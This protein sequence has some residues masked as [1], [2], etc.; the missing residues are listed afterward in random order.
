MTA[1]VMV[2]LGTLAQPVT[3]NA[4]VPVATVPVAAATSCYGGAVGWKTG[5]FG[6]SSTE[7]FGPYYTTSRCT[8]INMRMTSAPDAMVASACVRFG[9]PTAA[10]NRYTDFT[11]A[12]NSWKTIATTVLDG[13]KFYVTVF[14]GNG[15]YPVLGQFA[16]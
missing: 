9:S 8:D 5:P 14:N 11:E 16:F 7:T 10:C 6:L 13:T 12:L 4:A 15:G 1:L 3:A 2:A